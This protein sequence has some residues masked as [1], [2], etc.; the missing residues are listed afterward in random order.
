MEEE[1]LIESDFSKNKGSDVIRYSGIRDK[2]GPGD[3]RVYRRGLR[4][5]IEDDEDYRRGSRGRR[6]GDHGSLNEEGEH[7]L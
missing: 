1:N 7:S 5:M 3:D 2:S 6:A 4:E